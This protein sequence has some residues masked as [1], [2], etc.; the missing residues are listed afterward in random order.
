MDF[1]FILAQA[2]SKLYHI[3]THK[4]IKTTNIEIKKQN[5]HF[6]ILVKIFLK[7]LDLIIFFFFFILFRNKNLKSSTPPLSSRPCFDGIS[8]YVPLS[9]SLSLERILSLVLLE[10]WTIHEMMDVD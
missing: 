9:L 2:K 6:E 10:H 1:F 8:P 5:G 3:T 4:L 7:D